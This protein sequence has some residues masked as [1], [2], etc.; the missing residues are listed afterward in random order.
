MCRY[1]PALRNQG[2]TPD[3]TLE[4]INSARTS[5]S[6][7]TTLYT[8]VKL[9][10]ILEC[11]RFFQ[12]WNVAHYVLSVT[13]RQT[14]N[15]S[16]YPNNLNRLS[17]YLHTSLV[18]LLTYMHPQ[19]EWHNS[20]KFVLR[21]ISLIGLGTGKMSEEYSYSQVTTGWRQR[22]KSEIVWRNKMILKNFIHAFTA[23]CRTKCY[24]TVKTGDYSFI[25]PVVGGN[26]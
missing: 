22:R 2:L 16:Q 14:A 8:C 3:S 17:S 12:K 15:K 11:S 26:F 25:S 23:A 5:I 9:V 21:I 20:K 10:R 18:T 7:K 6:C 1:K 4:V 24:V 13:W 19:E